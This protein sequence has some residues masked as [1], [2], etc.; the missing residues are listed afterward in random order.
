L[1]SIEDVIPLLKKFVIR[2]SEIVDLQF[3]SKIPPKLL[4]NP[5]SKDYQS[6]KKI[7][8]YFLLVNS[9]D[10]SRVIGRAENSRCLM[11]ELHKKFGDTLFEVSEPNEFRE[12]VIQSRRYGEHGPLKDQIPVI[13]ASVNAF[14]NKEA[15]GDLIKY[16]QTFDQPKEMIEELGRHIVRMGGPTHTKAWVYMRWMVRPKPDPRIYSHFAPRDL[17]IP[18]TKDIKRVAACLEL[19]EQDKVS[20]WEQ[21][22]DVERVTAFCKRLF[23]NDP[24]KADYPF[25]LVGR[26][27]EGKTLNIKN[28]IRTL[29]IFD[30]FYGRTKCS[31]LLKKE[32]TRYSA[33]C[34][35]LPGCITEADT[36]QEVLL[37]MEN[38][39]AAYRES[40]NKNYAKVK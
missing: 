3:D 36:E 35:M 17:F 11:V 15:S 28:L 38:A 39:I 25:F 34:P 21:W 23:P 20:G 1:S 6:K 14:V 32:K 26:W 18:L 29:K 40:A 4:I 24:V 19:I 33:E 13:L 37:R 5:R 31:I 9:I 2:N 7:A 22:D 30:A 10:E 27:L 16:S 12:E 8:H